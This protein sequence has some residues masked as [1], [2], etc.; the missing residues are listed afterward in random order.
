[1][2]LIHVIPAALLLTSLSACSQRDSSEANPEPSGTGTTAATSTATVN[3]APQ[4]AAP[5]STDTEATDAGNGTTAP[6]T[7]PVDGGGPATRRITFSPGKSSANASGSIAGESIIDYLLNVRSGQP[8][9]ISMAT[10]NAANYFNVMEP[11]EQNAAIFIGSTAGNQFEGIARRS[12]D[13]RIRVYLMRSAARRG[14]VA[15]YRLE[16]VVGGTSRPTQAPG[17]SNKSADTGQLEKKCQEKVVRVTGSKVTGTSRIEH[18]EAAT[19]IYV[20][21]KGAQAPWR[22]LGYRDG[23]IGEVIYTG[24]EGAL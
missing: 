11:G 8:L 18:S 15:K 19:A 20:T 1:M 6:M 12:G 23:T 4:E 14:E 16:T 13:Y 21:V 10:N 2:K 24:S 17:V 5:T 3:E 22:C 7:P 9:N